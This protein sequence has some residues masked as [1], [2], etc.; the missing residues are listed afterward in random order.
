[1]HRWSLSTVLRALQWPYWMWLG[2]GLLQ[3]RSIRVSSATAARVRAA[4]CWHWQIWGLPR[5]L[6]STGSA[7]VGLGSLSADCLR[8]RRESR[9]SGPVGRGHL[10][11]RDR[12]QWQQSHVSHHSTDW[13]NKWISFCLCRGHCLCHYRSTTN[14]HFDWICVL[15]TVGLI[16]YQCVDLI[17]FFYQQSIMACLVLSSIWAFEKTILN[18]GLWCQN[19]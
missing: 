15:K 5:C 6:R 7:L 2:R 14:H 16:V 8:L 3:S 19:L 4:H 1:M 10:Q 17:A 11:K 12:N 9:L 13:D 18:Q